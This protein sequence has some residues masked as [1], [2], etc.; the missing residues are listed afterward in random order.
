MMT[1]LVVLVFIAALIVFIAAALRKPRG[2]PYA[3]HDAHVESELARLKA[4]GV[5]PTGNIWK[6]LE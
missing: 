6:E 5:E 1:I 4:A 3:A 2:N